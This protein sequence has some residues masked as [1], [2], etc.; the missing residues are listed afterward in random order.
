MVVEH[1]DFREF[2]LRAHRVDFELAEQPAD[3]DMLRGVEMLVAQEH[4]LVLDQRRFECLEG[5]RIEPVLE[6][7]AVDF[8]AQPRAMTFDLE[9]GGACAQLFGGDVDVHGVPRSAA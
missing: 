3:R 4:H 9:R 5:F 1:Q 2:A 7:E 8:G 6:I